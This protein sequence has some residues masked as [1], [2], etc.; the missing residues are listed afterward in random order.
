MKPGFKSTEF[1][2]SVVAAIAGLLMA[3]GVLIEGSI[4]T[5]IV[6]GVIAILSGLG[7][8]YSRTTIKTQ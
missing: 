1:W 4:V 2:L 3:S 5:Q 7:Y 8:T 6:G